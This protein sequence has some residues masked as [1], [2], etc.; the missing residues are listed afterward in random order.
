[1]PRLRPSSETSVPLVALC[2]VVL[3]GTSALPVA[4]QSTPSEQSYVSVTNVTHT[5]ETPEPGETFEVEAVV[6]NHAGTGG[7]FT[8][9]EVF[10]RGPETNAY[11]ADD[12]GKLPE[13]ASMP[14]TLPVSVD[15][16]GQ[17]TFTVYVYGRDASGNAVSIQHPVSVTVEAEPDPQVELEVRDAVANAKRPVNVTVGNGRESPLR[18][19]SVSVSSPTAEFAVR[20]RVQATVPAGNTTTFRFPA[21]VDDPGTYPVNVSLSYI[22]DGQRRY[23]NRTFRANF[24]AP[25]N[26]GR[27]TLTGVDAVSRG[28]TLE[29]SATASNLGSSQVEGVVVSVADAPAVGSADY[30]VGEIDGSDFSSFTLTASVTGNVSSVPVEVRYVVD[31]VEKTT[32]TDV[33][34]ERRV[35]RE[36]T[37]DEGGLPLVPIAAGVVAL[38]ALVGVYRW[39]R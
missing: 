14:V 27:V 35:V 23:V 26:P 10:V 29:L 20:E 28:G 39:R 5:P 31:G 32:V 4:A 25:S 34:V 24:G 21:V 12:L 36:P 38:V 8:V 15:E 3:V 33:P 18:Q 37:R 13:G 16:P 7:P 30:F 22:D 19:V 9:N 11:I 2:L 1:M 17:Y 6:E